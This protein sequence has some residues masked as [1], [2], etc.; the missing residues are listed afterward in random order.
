MEITWLGHSCF[1]I[2]GKEAILVTDPYQE[3]LGYPPSKLQANIVT[4][5]HQ[6]P[7]HNYVA[8]V[9]G[10]PK[11]LKGPGEYEIA[12]VF[13]RGIKTFHDSIQGG[14]QGKNTIY[15]M[16]MDRVNLCHLGDLGHMPSPQQIEEIGSIDVLLVPVGG[17]STIDARV[18][19]EIVRLLNPKIVIPM[20]Y[21]TEVVTWLEPVD[22]FLREMGLREIAPQSKILITRSNLPSQ[23]QVVVLDR[24]II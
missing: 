8:G 5:T 14:K 1:R 20:H 10:N 11:V 2:K 19:A 22:R 16:E 12:E 4:L 17:V 18:A 24:M 13:I 7:G 15:I 9:E 23:T 6:H 3:S 21:R